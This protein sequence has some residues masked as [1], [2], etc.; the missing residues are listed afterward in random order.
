MKQVW[1]CDFC[2]HTQDKIFGMKEHEE[3]CSFNP[4]NK[5]CFTCKHAW[6]SGHD[7]PIPECEKN[8][9]TT[10]GRDKGNCTEWKSDSV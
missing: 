6:D 7:F 10:D 5:K 3:N 1:K 9:S 2:S 8:L 4:L